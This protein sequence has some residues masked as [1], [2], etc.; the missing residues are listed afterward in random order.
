MKKIAI[1]TLGV[2]MTATLGMAVGCQGTR[3]EIVVT[4]D[5]AEIVNGGFESADLSGW[6]VEYG[7]AFDDDCVSS[8][9]TFSFPEDEKQ[10]AISVNQTGNWYLCGKAFDGKYSNART[11]A[12]RSTKFTLSGDGSIS[13]KLAG[14]AT[15][16]G[17][18]EAAAKKATEKLCFVG[19]YRAKDD[20]LI[21]MQTNEYF[22]E[23]TESYVNPS[24]YSAGVYNTDNFYVYARQLGYL[25]RCGERSR[26][27][28]GKRCVG[29]GT[30]RGQ[31]RCE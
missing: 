28:H 31:R 15:M 17:K 24:K 3:K 29:L 30:I 14:G 11:G 13:M 2:L 6:T 8:V 20:R 4:D 1:I 16:V 21:G 7:N 10:N 27:G 9:K 26:D 25:C 12:I 5:Y 18:G 22:L 23:H 19:V